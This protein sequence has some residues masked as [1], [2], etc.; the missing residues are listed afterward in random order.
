MLLLPATAIAVTLLALAGRGDPAGLA[1]FA[2]AMLAY[3]IFWIALTAAVNLF[4]RTST[5]AALACGTIWLAVV[6]LLPAALSAAVDLAA[7]PPS[8]SAYA[9][10]IRAAGLEVRA[11]NAAAS[12]AAATASTDR[13]YP[14][15]LWHSRG[16]IQQRDAQLAPIHRAHAAR[17]AANRS[18]ADAA[19]FLSPAVIVQDALDRIAGTDAA[20]ALAFQDQARAFAGSTRRLAFDWMDADRL[21]TLADYDG[22]LPRFA[23]QEPRAALPLALDL[24]AL[25]LFALLL[26]A[27]AAHR[28]RC[29]A[30]A[31][32]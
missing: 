6:V 10:S 15:S 17:W 4:V 22:G 18:L 32:L 24:G 8:G 2:L 21:M 26:L 23:F 19:R 16:E 3:G 20:R 9:N 11:A 25:A 31:L 14:A 13:A 7:P 29:G 5:T 28:L 30:Q 1:L 12:R 27:I